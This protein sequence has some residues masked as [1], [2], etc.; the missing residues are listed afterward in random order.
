MLAADVS[1][2][3]Y[4][5]IWIVEEECW[6]DGVTMELEMKWD[7]NPNIVLDINTHIGVAL[8]VQVIYINIYIFPNCWCFLYADY[9]CEKIIYC[10]LL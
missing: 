2:W 1:C 8:P 10:S 7:G 3:K 4:V 5:G 9:L 6:D